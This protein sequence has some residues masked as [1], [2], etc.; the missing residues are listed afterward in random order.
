MITILNK[1]R[2]AG[3]FTL[4]ALCGLANATTI[5]GTLN[6][7]GYSI[8][9]F[10]LAGDGTVGFRAINAGA[11]GATDPA[12]SLYD[13]AGHLIVAVD[14]FYG[15]LGEPGSLELMPRLN[16]N[17]AA[18]NYSLLIDACCIGWYQAINGGGT[19]IGTDGTNKGDYIFGGTSTLASTVSFLNGVEQ[20]R[21]PGKDWAIEVTGDISGRAE[22]PEPASVLLFGLGFAG[23]VASRRKSR[24]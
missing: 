1:L 9:N 12:F 18:G 19:G 5:S 3:A 13:G 16:Q 21:D 17:L 23:V 10:S 15:L 4:L 24:A 8:Y 7:Q 11:N 2:L 22:V 6:S 20:P 14:D